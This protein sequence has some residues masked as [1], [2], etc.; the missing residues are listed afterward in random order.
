[1]LTRSGTLILGWTD[2]GGADGVNELRAAL[3]TAFPGATHRQPAI[4]HT[5]LFRIVSPEALPADAIAAI[6]AECQRWTERLAGAVLAPR[7]LWFVN[8]LQFST[9]EGEREILALAS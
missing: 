7:S 1:M 5:T 2:A 6:G 9:I 4:I 8:E 3:R